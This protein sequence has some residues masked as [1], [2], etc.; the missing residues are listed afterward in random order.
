MAGRTKRV[1]T[2]ALRYG[3]RAVYLVSALSLASGTLALL[4]A[5]KA[6]AATLPAVSQSSDSYVVVSGSGNYLQTVDSN[7]GGTVG[8]AV[9]LSATPV[10]VDEYYPDAG[11]SKVIV[12]E[13]TSS[14]GGQ[15]EM[16][17]PGSGDMSTPVALAAQPSAIVM[18]HAVPYALVLEPIYDQV[19]VF[20]PQTNKIV[21]TVSLGLGQNVGMTIAMGPSGEDAYVTGGDVHKVVTLSYQSSAPY[22]VASSTYIGS[23]SFVPSAITLSP[24]TS[25]D[26]AYVSSGSDIYPCTT[27]STFACSSPIALGATAGESAV[28]SNSSMLYVGTGSDIT[29]VDL[30]N[31]NKVSSW[32]TPGFSVGNVFL[33][34]DDSTL[35]VGSASGAQL[36]FLNVTDGT[37]LQP[38]LALDGTPQ[39]AVQSYYA[40]DRL[41][42][43]V[44]LSDTNQVAAF[45]PYAETD[46]QKIAVGNDPVA[47]AVSP[48]G[49]Y[50]YAV[51]KA[52]NTVS[53]I[54]QANIDSGTAPVTNTITV[55]T[56]PDA[57][58][59][60]PTGAFALVADGG[61]G[62]TEINNPDSSS[63][64]TSHIGLPT[65][66]DPTSI[67]FSPDGS[68]AYVTD[69][70]NDDVVVL[71]LESGAYVSIGGSGSVAET[72]TSVAIA[73][74]DQTAYVTESPS[75]GSGQLYQFPI[76]SDGT[77]NTLSA[78]SSTVGV[79]PSGVVL[80]GNGDTAYVSNEGSS[81]IS[82]VSLPAGTVSNSVFN[83]SV[84][85]TDTS[86]G[87]SPDGGIILDTN[88]SK[89]TM[90]IFGPKGGLQKNFSFTAGSDPTAV[91]FSPSL[92]DPAGKSMSGY[93]QDTNSLV[94]ASSNGIDNIAGVNLA[95]GSYVLPID[96]F[97]L[98]VIGGSLDLKEE[99]NSDNIGVSNPIGFGPGWS[100]PY[101]W[102]YTENSPGTSQSACDIIVT[103][104]NGTKVYF[105]PHDPGTWTTSCPTS[106]YETPGFEQA[107]LSFVSSCVG[108]DS[109]IKVTSYA[110]TSYYIDEST[111]DLVKIVDQNNN[112][113]TLS[114]SANN[115]TVT[116]PGG[117]YLSFTLSGSSGS[118]ITEVT[119]S[120]GR[121]ASFNYSGGELASVTLDASATGDTQ[122]HT[123]D[124]SYDSNNYLTEWWS[125]DNSSGQPPAEG[126]QIAYSGSYPTSV[127]QPQV[128][129]CQV[130]GGTKSPCSP[131]TTF[132]WPNAD[133]VLIKDPNWNAGLP[134][135][136]QTL[137][138]YVN[139]ALVLEVQGYGRTSS[140]ADEQASSV[141]YELN[142]P[143]TLMPTM[144]FD[145]D[146]NETQDTYDSSGNV[147]SEVDP[148]GNT[149]SYVYNA[150][151]EVVQETDPLGNVTSYTYDSHGNQLT[152]TDP[153]GNVTTNHYNSVGELCATLSPDG[154][155]AGDS[156]TG[157]PTTAEPYVTTYGYDSSGDLTSTTNYDGTGNTATET[158]VTTELYNSAGE[159]C[160]SLSADG[161]A[162][163]DRLSGS[164]PTTAAPFE[165]LETAYDVYAN[166]LSSTAP[167]N[168]NGG[169][170][171]N[172]YDADGNELTTETGGDVVTNAYDAEDNLCWT[173]N[174]SIS[175]AQCS[176]PPTGAGTTTTSDLYDPDGNEVAT[177]SPDGNQTPSVSCLYT[178]TNTYDNLGN[179]LSTTTPTGGTSCSNVT[180]STTTN[181]YDGAGN[182]LTSKA[183]G[184]LS[185][186]TYDG[187]GN[188]LT[189]DVGGIETT[190]TYD[191]DGNELTSTVGSGS[192]SS[193][194]TTTYDGDGN[195]CWTEPAVV[196]NPGCGNVPSGSGTISYSYDHNGN[197][198]TADNGGVVTT[199]TYD[200]QNRLATSVLGTDAAKSYSYDADGSVTNASQGGSSETDTYNGAGQLIEK[201]YTDGT[202]TVS[203]QWGSNGE[204]CWM[205]Q[206]GVST[207]SCDSPPSPTGSENLT[208]YG[209]DTSGNLTSQVTTTSSSAS[210]TTYG[211]D[212]SG[213]LDCL[214]YPDSGANTCS[215]P[216]T[217][218]GIVTYSY[219]GAGQLA[220]MS[221]WEQNAF[222]F[223][224]NSAG[225][226][227]WVSTGSASS[228]S[229]A[230]PPSGTGAVTTA[231]SYDSN[232]QL[233]NSATT[234]AGSNLLSF[235]VA[236][237]TQGFITSETPTVGSTAEATDTYGYNSSN[238]IASGPI[239]G[240]SSQN[241]YA[242]ST[243]GSITTDA[244]AFQSAAYNS[245]GEL[246]WTLTASSTNGCAS[247]PSGATT[248]AYNTD[249][250]R[251]GVT[252]PS[253]NPS[254]YGW[255]S[256]SG[257]LTC[258][259]TDGTTC[260]VTSPTSSTTVY[261]YD[262][263]GLRTSATQNGA[264]TSFAWGQIAGNPSL[265]TDGTW[266]S[267]YVPGTASPLEQIGVSSATADMLVAD[268]S[269]NTRGIV[270]LSSGASQG[271][272]VNYTD[273]DAYGNPITAPGGSSEVGGISQ[274]QT[275][276]DP[277]YAGT[278]PWMFGEGYTDSTSLVLL[279][280]RYYD[281]HTG[282]FL[283]IDSAVAIT[284]QTY[285][286]SG[287]NPINWTDP[288]GTERVKGPGG[289]DDNPW[290][291]VRGYI[292]YRGR[293][294]LM[295]QGIWRS[296]QGT[297]WGFEKIVNKHP[298]ILPIIGLVLRNGRIVSR[299]GEAARYELRNQCNG[300]VAV[301]VV[302]FKGQKGIITGRIGG[303]GLVWAIEQEF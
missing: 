82:K 170:T 88:S 158:Y 166:A 199:N 222:S 168:S 193:T 1:K 181:T 163:G 43:Y 17:S 257:L 25:S 267:L 129:S 280:S 81:F 255:E 208:T 180:S 248:Y 5:A 164:C 187:D 210:T 221:D 295:R 97:S 66:N 184:V 3:Q 270:Q 124:F 293:P 302:E 169:T 115:L 55:G 89:D 225:Q 114:Y 20:D 8:N 2:R 45:D 78:T 204:Q 110:G 165:T 118:D 72:P 172:T 139:G 256:A 60:S 39:G 111:D 11:A 240:T 177:V 128:S 179:A 83:N 123:W 250:E 38:T 13:T 297:G 239:T 154:N 22:W 245:S 52:D 207:A 159:Q 155:A 6:S 79:S 41:I 48:T 119:D 294:V 157:C 67:T 40:T 278:T 14:G 69:A 272:L 27:S 287:N 44:A 77:L 133:T 26:S 91:A 73:P 185:T 175:G 31:G 213:Q 116:G 230:S 276:I 85:D 227:C 186:Y 284:N 232:G 195:V 58:A 95:A 23:S 268:P 105:Y 220:T 262:G 235:A 74:N 57:I 160:A 99:Y 145:G 253:G 16:M 152:E 131:E 108:T 224:Y 18:S 9:P 275:G 167:S 254:S 71:K 61:G 260:S 42:A 196:S 101:Y 140:G 162:T 143:F 92:F 96:N 231:Y 109:C 80:S 258:V 247:P 112:T 90:S 51:N 15:V 233:S 106:Y 156:L 291:V 98:P 64:A 147:M 149:T 126:T 252:P 219:N 198:L 212:S 242:Y 102:S 300:D 135:G 205:F 298:E 234:S 279:T 12:A 130:S 132:G 70:G 191:G 299:Q 266:D 76:E 171:T 236:R 292:D 188:E 286:Y 49:Q 29:T 30:A 53:V 107:H 24:Q 206:G 19:Q 296:K 34:H 176:S 217:G 183:G 56:S 141:T 65:G 75:S 277:N 282:Q 146:G 228:P 246:C 150:F 46:V 59:L 93:E 62:V 87:L 288:A 174:T 104:G 301:V 251:T 263:N 285:Q 120:A 94:A 32:S 192:T 4:P 148:L 241:S 261:S 202:P 127:T 50:A 122:T 237:N 223:F 200:E 269:G 209:Y 216:G 281:P 36:A 197:Q 265:L 54:S 35:G 194:T 214:S 244:T 283:S 249:G 68:F 21:A 7:T 103:E 117:R 229:C 100:F 290:R 271:Q 84:I 303:P 137:E 274:P 189:S 138:R 218:I 10:G 182:E 113:T 28:N 289:N 134:N 37:A 161:Y 215:S 63:P 47:V 173:E 121:T 144:S 125:P 151:D 238:Q 273:Y 142:D 226:I 259:N 203:Y 201:S 190:S 153:D 211:Y 243:G 264:T 86:V 178:T 136:N 33:T